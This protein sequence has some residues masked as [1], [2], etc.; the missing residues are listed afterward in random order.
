MKKRLTQEKYW[1]KNP[2]RDGL[3]KYS[4]EDGFEEKEWVMWGN[5]R[6]KTGELIVDN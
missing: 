1:S 3:V 2:D 4:F 6:G 5:R